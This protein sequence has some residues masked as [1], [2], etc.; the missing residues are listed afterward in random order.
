MDPS[1]SSK[2]RSKTKIVITKSYDIAKKRTSTPVRAFNKKNQGFV[3]RN[4]GKIAAATALAALAVIGLTAPTIY[5][6]HGEAL[7]RGVEEYKRMVEGAAKK[8]LAIAKEQQDL[9]SGAK[10]ARDLAELKVNQEKSM[11]LAREAEE[12]TRKSLLAKQELELAQKKLEEQRKI[13]EMNA[14]IAQL[15]DQERAEKEQEKEREIILQRQEEMKLIQQQEQ[16]RKAEEIKQIT[17]RQAKEQQLQEFYRQQEERIRL[18]KQKE[19][20]A[21]RDRNI[22]IDEKNNKM[23]VKLREA[24]NPK[25]CSSQDQEKLEQKLRRRTQGIINYMRKIEQCKDRTVLSIL[26]DENE[27]VP[28]E[29]ISKM[30][31]DYLEGNNTLR[32][33]INNCKNK[34]VRDANAMY[35]DN[36]RNAKSKVDTGI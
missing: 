18:Q 1:V 6:K 34:K 32:L 31:A 24:K 7:K 29:N 33:H 26:D 25:D 5:S 10:A 19:M 12:L 3:S 28:C 16:S 36:I 35:F 22:L 27:V 11:A 14:K 20:V 21:D 15:Q 8:L 23:A 17:I 2:L 4:R 9:F 13:D 30:K